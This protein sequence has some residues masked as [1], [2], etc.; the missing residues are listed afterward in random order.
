MKKLII[1]VVCML[2]VDVILAQTG[3]SRFQGNMGG[4]AGGGSAVPVDGGLSAMVVGSLIYGY[5]KVKE[6]IQK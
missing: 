5:K 3:M 4:T 6:N 2:V 1:F